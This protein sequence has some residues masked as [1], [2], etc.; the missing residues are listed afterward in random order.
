MSCAPHKVKYRKKN[1]TSLSIKGTEMNIKG[2][3]LALHYLSVEA[4][5]A[6]LSELAVT[7]EDAAAKCNLYITEN[8]RSC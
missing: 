8:T 6:G 7:L 5:N 4:E 1:V 3:S 2:I